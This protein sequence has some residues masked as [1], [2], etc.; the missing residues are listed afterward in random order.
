MWKKHSTFLVSATFN[1]YDAIEFG[2]DLKKKVSSLFKKYPFI[3]I[4]SFLKTYVQIISELFTNWIQ[5]ID[6]DFCQKKW[7]VILLITARH[8]Q[9]MF[10]FQQHKNLIL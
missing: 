10:S 8:M 2:W 7:N 4:L 3:L 5:Q 9:N 1:F 6:N